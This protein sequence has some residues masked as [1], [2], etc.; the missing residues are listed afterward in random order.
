MSVFAVAS[1][2]QHVGFPIIINNK[3][4]IRSN[5]TVR[6]PSPQKPTSFCISFAA[7]GI[8]WKQK[9]NK[10]TLVSIES[11]PPSS[12]SLGSRHDYEVLFKNANYRRTQTAAHT[13]THTYTNAQNT[14]TSGLVWLVRNTWTCPITRSP[15]LG[16]CVCV[17]ITHSNE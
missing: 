17:F 10:K 16:V 13:H 3:W 9:T 6:K 11:T 2:V 4:D 5:Q 8:T 12:P 7:N 14:Q 1:H 15:C